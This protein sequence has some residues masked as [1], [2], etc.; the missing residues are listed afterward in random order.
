MKKILKII[1]IIFITLVVGF[2]AV[3]AAFALDLASYTAT[4]SE[5]LKHTGTSI[6]QALVVYDPGF[7]GA[8]KQ[9]ASKIAEDLQAKGYTVDLA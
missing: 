5:T 1:A 2:G 9:A 3:F 7:S 8:A 4:S 6:G